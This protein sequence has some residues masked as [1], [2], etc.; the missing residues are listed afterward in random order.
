[1]KFFL[2]GKSIR[3]LCYFQASVLSEADVEE[4][5]TWQVGGP[6]RLYMLCDNCD[7][8]IQYFHRVREE[9]L[10]IYLIFTSIKMHVYG[11]QSALSH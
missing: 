1:M 3:M 5:L 9:Q 10:R 2:I 4:G 8:R 11:K 6:S 7:V